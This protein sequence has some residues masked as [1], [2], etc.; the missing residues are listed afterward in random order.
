MYKFLF[1]HLL[2]ILLGMK[3]RSEISGS[4]ANTMLDKVLSS[5][6]KWKISW[7]KLAQDHSVV[8]IRVGI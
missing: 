7:C 1:E 2:S 8:S 3:F 4:C 6:D 5:L